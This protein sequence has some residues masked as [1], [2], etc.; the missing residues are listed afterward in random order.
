[1]RVMRVAIIEKKNGLSRLRIS[2]K[3]SKRCYVPAYVLFVVRT[4][5]EYFEGVVM[6]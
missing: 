2:F 4:D 3:L 1:M 5:P 6:L